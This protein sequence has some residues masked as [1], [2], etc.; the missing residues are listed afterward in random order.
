MMD[1]VDEDLLLRDT[2]FLMGRLLK[3]IKGLEPNNL[4]AAEAMTFLANNELLHLTRNQTCIQG[5]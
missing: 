1:K 5:D 2:V 3:V 4:I